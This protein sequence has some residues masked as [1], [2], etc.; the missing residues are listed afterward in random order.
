MGAEAVVG[1]N[2][3][4]VVVWVADGMAE[5]Q[6]A[7][8]TTKLLVSSKS[9]SS[10]RKAYSTFPTARCGGVQSKK[11]PSMVSNSWAAFPVFTSTMYSVKGGAPPVQE[12]VTGLHGVTSEN[13][14]VSNRR[15]RR[16]CTPVRT[17][18]REQR[19]R[20]DR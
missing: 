13:E 4:A 7:D 6:D 18:R 17:Q 12:N 3:M 10:E 20:R 19:T 5:K 8:C 11:S 16:P 2:G 15:V 14:I 9:S 1:G